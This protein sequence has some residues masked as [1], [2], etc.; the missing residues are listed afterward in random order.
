MK[1]IIQLNQMM[2]MTVFF[3]LSSSAINCP[4]DMRL[5]FKIEERA[6]GQIIYII[7]R[8]SFSRYIECIINSKY[9]P[10]RP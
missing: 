10:F 3:N 7:K 1:I 8:E 4:Q 9:S 6:K 2:R 5:Q